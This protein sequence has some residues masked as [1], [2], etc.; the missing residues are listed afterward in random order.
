MLP[1]VTRAEALLPFARL[2]VE[3]LGRG[4]GS[5]FPA[6]EVAAA[7][8]MQHRIFAH[9]G[10]IGDALPDMLLRPSD[11][12][13]HSLLSALLP[14]VRAALRG[15]GAAM[16]SAGECQCCWRWVYTQYAASA[17]HHKLFSA[18]DCCY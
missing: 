8:Q 12:P 13:L 11:V 5:A 17:G 18:S 3:M 14:L 10:Q 16:A 4:T 2:E 15:V 1:V 9:L 7:L 6:H